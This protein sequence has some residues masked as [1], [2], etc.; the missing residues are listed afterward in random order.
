MRGD[1]HEREDAEVLAGRRPPARPGHGDVRHAVRPPQMGH[2]ERNLSNTEFGRGRNHLSDVFATLAMLAFLID[3]VQQHC[4]PVF[5]K[6]RKHQ[7]RIPASGTGC[8]SW[9]GHSR[10]RT[11][12]PTSARSRGSSARRTA[13]AAAAPA[14]LDRSRSRPSPKL[15]NLGQPPSLQSCAPDAVGTCRRPER[16]SDGPM[17]RLPGI[18]ARDAD[19]LDR[20]EPSMS[21][22]LFEDS[23][24]FAGT[25]PGTSC[26][27]FGC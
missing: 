19:G 25:E 12:G 9:S 6:A 24:G 7:K 13:L 18:A 22:F 27:Y 16:P 1:R 2:R 26:R 20:S 23:G 11:G 5:G 4:C 3:Q 15:R 17:A 8:G 14:S 21:C 10:S